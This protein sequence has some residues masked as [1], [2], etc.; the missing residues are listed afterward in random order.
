MGGALGTT[1]A[2]SIATVDLFLAFTG[3]VLTTACS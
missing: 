2:F 1:L 3:E